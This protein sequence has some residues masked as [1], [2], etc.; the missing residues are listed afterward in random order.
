MPARPKLVQRIAA[1]ARARKWHRQKW[2]RHLGIP[3][4]KAVAERD[5]T[6]THHWV[7]GRRIRLN[8]FRHKGYW[9]HGN[10]REPGVMASLAKLVGPGDTVIDVGGHIG[11]VS[12]YLAH[13]VGPTGRVFVFE[14]SPDNLRYLTANTKA[15]APIEIVRKAVSDSNGHAQFFTENLTGQ[16]STLI[17]NYAHFDETRRSAQIDET[18]QA[19]EVETTTLDAFVAER[20]ITPDFIKIDIEG[21]EALAVRGMGAVLASHHPKLMVEITREED[22]VMGLLREAGYA[23]CDSRLRPLADGATTGP[24]RFFL[25]D[26]AQLS[27]AASG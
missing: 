22:E 15:V 25:P 19:M 6:I 8:A 9:F 24:N 7:P 26:E 14:P 13:L 5:I 12:L 3:L 27:Q 16:N 18:Y 21:A 2:L 23:A 20:G 11:Y 4:L 10:R 1:Y 17:E